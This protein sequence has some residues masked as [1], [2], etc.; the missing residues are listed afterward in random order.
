MVSDAGGKL[1]VGIL[2]TVVGF[3][4][5]EKV[6]LTLIENLDRDHFDIELVIFTRPDQKDNVF[7]QN[8]EKAGTPCHKIYADKHRFKYLNPVTNLFDAYSFFKKSR[9]ALIHT[10]GYRADVLGI[11][12]AKLISLPVVSTCHGFIS[13]DSNRSFYNRLDRFILRFFS[14]IMAVSEGIKEDLLRSGVKESLIEVLPN[15]IDTGGE[16]AK[17]YRRHFGDLPGQIR[18]GDFVLGFV[19]R[20]SEEKGVKYLIEAMALIKHEGLPVKLLVIGEGP[21]EESLLELVERLNIGDD[22]F[23]VG[24]Q[25]EMEKWYPEIDVFVLPSLTEGTP[26]SLLEAMAAGVP[27]VASDVGGV[28]DI[29][30]TSVNGMLVKP[31]KP[32]ELKGAIVSLFKDAA[33]RERIAEWGLQ[34]LRSRYSISSWIE[35]LESVYLKTAKESN[36]VYY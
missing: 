34:T 35:R 12:I 30:Q 23:F 10:H 32:E 2:A 27:V 31:E 17:V 9:C 18:E 28:P 13:I 24:F 20:L 8:L 14:G 16:P 36:D 22:V 19:G 11:L 25:N 6:I 29:I 15:A 7:F 1:K 5:A 26:M 21:E 33:L 4:G 3:G